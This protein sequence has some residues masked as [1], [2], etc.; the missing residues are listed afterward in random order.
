MRGFCSVA[1]ARC[2]GRQHLGRDERL[3]ERGE[4]GEGLSKQPRDGPSKFDHRG[5]RMLRARGRENRC[6][7]AAARLLIVTVLS[8][9]SPTALH[10]P[11]VQLSAGWSFARLSVQPPR[12]GFGWTLGLRGG[13]SKNNKYVIAAPFPPPVYQSCTF[14]CAPECFLRG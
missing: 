1:S 8:A 14:V 10:G 5:N 13:A 6:A 11:T 2:A 9:L 4:C 7:V 12:P 3:A